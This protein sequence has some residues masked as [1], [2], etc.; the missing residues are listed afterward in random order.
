VDPV[1]DPLLLKKSGSAGNRTLATDPE[2]P[3]SIPIYIYWFQRMASS[4]GRVE[5]GMVPNPDLWGQ[6]IRY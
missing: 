5:G 2:I 1:S 3:G 4:M 6:G